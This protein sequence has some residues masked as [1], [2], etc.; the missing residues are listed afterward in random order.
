MTRVEH[1]CWGLQPL[2]VPVVAVAVAVAVAGRAYASETPD[3]FPAV[4]ETNHQMLTNVPN[5][6]ERTLSQKL[7]ISQSTQPT[8]MC[9]FI[10]LFHYI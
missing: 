5:N 10:I 2:R 3:V 4:M 6:I 7:H 8:R 9:S 1:R